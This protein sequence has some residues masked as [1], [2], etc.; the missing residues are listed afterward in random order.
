MTQLHF[1]CVPQVCL[2]S[3]SPILPFSLS[4]SHLFPCLY[5]FLLL[6][7]F[8]IILFTPFCACLR[9]PIPDAAYAISEIKGPMEEPQLIFEDPQPLS[10]TE[11]GVMTCNS[12]T[13]YA[14]VRMTRCRF[15]DVRMVYVRRIAVL[16]AHVYSLA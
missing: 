11:A 3:V 9:A 7:P 10:F 15:F 16:Q 14:D 6:S 1:R 13:A 5:S 4:S 2:L 8:V 12:L